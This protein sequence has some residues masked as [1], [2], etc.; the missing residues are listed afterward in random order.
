MKA[1]TIKGRNAYYLYF[2]KEYI[3]KDYNP[4]QGAPE[5]PEDFLHRGNDIHI[6]NPKEHLPLLEAEIL[7]HF[8]TP[9]DLRLK[10]RHRELVMARRFF[11][12]F[13]SYYLGLTQKAITDYLNM[14]RSTACHHLE[15]FLVE[16]KLYREYRTIAQKIDKYLYEQFGQRNSDN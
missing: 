11:I 10:V 14:E 1:S 16:V 9:Y 3:P 15:A 12:F 6:D 8:R 13:A 4:P 5:K 7:K 2:Q